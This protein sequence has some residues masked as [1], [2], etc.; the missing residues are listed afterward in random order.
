MEDKRK[1]AAGHRWLGYGIAALIVLLA[2]S[3]GLTFYAGEAGS[4]AHRLYY[5]SLSPLLARVQESRLAA[6]ALPDVQAEAEKSAE[7]E[8][9]LGVVVADSAGRVVAAVPATLVGAQLPTQTVSWPEGRKQPWL[10]LWQYNQPTYVGRALGVTSG[11]EVGR[12]VETIWQGVSLDS[13][14][15]EFAY[16]WATVRQPLLWGRTAHGWRD[17]LI[18]ADLLLVLAGIL[19]LAFWVFADASKHGME[20][21]WAWGALTLITNAIGWATYLVVRS[22][23]RPRCANCGGILRPAY[24]VCPHCG[25]QL[26]RACPSCGQGVEHGWNFC[27]HC[28]AALN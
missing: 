6:D 3:L 13:G 8:G 16:V 5:G 7:G 9:W 18:A 27:P 1:G 10:E 19:A 11:D 15:T 23:Q 4:L 28:S 17:I 24:R 2:V 26:R 12:E 14:S 22:W 21:P 25:L 20:A